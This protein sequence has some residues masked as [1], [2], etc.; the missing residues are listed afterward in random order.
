MSSLALHPGASLLPHHPQC[1]VCK[2]G[3]PEPSVSLG[4]HA[5]TC[6]QSAQGACMLVPRTRARVRTAP[7][8]SHTGICPT[9]QPGC[10][11]HWPGYKTKLEGDGQPQAAG[12]TLASST[13]LSLTCQGRTWNLHPR[14]GGV[15]MGLPL[16]GSWASAPA[17][18]LHD[19]HGLCGFLG[20]LPPMN[21]SS[22]S[23]GPL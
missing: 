13:V 9:C 4:E 1:P 19:T 23:L 15:R 2:G 21:V 12:E 22:S 11:G 7:I 6:G 17:H 16:L 3:C 5:H 10:R 8:C 18:P 14:G 20:P